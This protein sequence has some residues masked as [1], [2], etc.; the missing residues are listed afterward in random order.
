MGVTAR[1]QGLTATD[2]ALSGSVAA[3]PLARRLE[4]SHWLSGFASLAVTL[5]GASVLIGW[6]ID[7]PHLKS[8]IPGLVAMNPVTAFCFVAAGLALWLLRTEG[9]PA[10]MQ[11]AGR[12]LAALVVVLPPLC[13]SRLYLPWDLA[14]DRLAFSAQVAVAS[15]GH[16]NRMA[17]NTG[18]NFVL[19][20]L[21]LLFLDGRTRRGWRPA[22]GLAVA[23]GVSALVAVFGYAYQSRL[24]Y[25]VGAF[26]PMAINTAAGFVLLSVGVLCARSEEGL[27]ALFLGDGPGA[28]LARRLVPAAF[29]IPPV[30]GWLALKGQT[31]GLFDPAGGLALL[32]TATT[33][34]MAGLIWLSAVSLDQSN[35]ARV[36]AE[37]NVR[38]LNEGLEARVVERT[39]E[40]ERVNEELRALF[41]ASPLAI[42]TLSTDSHV[43]SWNRAAEAL[44]GWTAEEVIGRFPPIVPPDLVGEMERLRDRVMTG[45]P[46]ANHETQ[47]VRKDGHRL[48]LSLSTAS[49]FDKSGATC[50]VVVVYADVGDRKALEAQLRQAQKMEAVGRLAGGVAHDFNNILTAIRTAAEFLLVDLDGEDPRR[51]DATEIRD[52]ADRGAGL[53]RQLLAFSRQQVLQPRVVDL[54]AV[55]TAIEPMVRRLVEENIDLVTRLGVGLDRVQ[56]DPNQLEQ[57]LLNLVV[58]ARDAMPDGGILLIET[59]NVVL[60]EEYPRTHATARPG[61]HVLLSVTD[62]GCGMD[63]GTQARVFEPFFTTKPIGQGTGLG[64]ATVYGIV[65]Q[66]GGHIWVYSE[67]GRGTSFKIYFPRHTG[68]GEAEAPAESCQDE[69]ARAVPDAT[70]LLVEDDIAVRNVVRRLLERH[71]YR[72]VDVPTGGQALTTLAD[73]ALAVD[74][75]ISDIVM[76]EMSGLELRER[77]RT[78]RPGLPLLLMSGYSQEAITRLGNPAS[79]GPLVEKPFTAQAILESVRRVLTM[80]ARDA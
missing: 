26:I 74:L 12:V 18:L 32:A 36:R 69:A 47:R 64:L 52:A 78:L 54:N 44:F 42:C 39:R 22:E 30:L 40:V 3:E 10:R 79:L 43:L 25:G 59:A 14:L 76:P 73:S 2:R 20:G 71:G 46:L 61:P 9:A 80:E 48:E 37:Q 6:R 24:L 68:P 72:V 7:Q 11:L 19:V 15:G 60:D 23:A 13:L 17:P 65:K 77:L 34:T 53:T 50:G 1:L 27:L 45:Q 63:A 21:A 70:I 58:N 62:T 28:Q 55:V 33:L 8:G 57:V 75:V 67:V 38:R 4:R 16:P 56:A 66:S 49:L 5:L 29:I 31:A 35:H 51:A 41:E